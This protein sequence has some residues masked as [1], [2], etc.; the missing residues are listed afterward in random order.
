MIFYLAK[1]G[2]DD[3]QGEANNDIIIGGAGH[4]KLDGGTGADVLID[5]DG[6]DLVMGG[7]GN[8]VLIGSHSALG[9]S[10]PGTDEGDAL[11]G[12]TVVAG[13]ELF[14]F[15]VVMVIDSSRSMGAVA[16]DLVANVN[17]NAILSTHNEFQIRGLPAGT[18][19]ES[20]GGFQ[21]IVGGPGFYS[22]SMTKAQLDNLVIQL[23]GAE[24]AGGATPADFSLDVRGR[25]T[26][27]DPFQE[28][29]GFSTAFG[30]SAA[31]VSVRNA[32]ESLNQNFIDNGFDATTQVRV[33][34]FNNAA[35]VEV[36]GV[37]TDF[38]PSDPNLQTVIEGITPL[39]E[40]DFDVGI[41]EA[42]NHL[43]TVSGT[44]IIYF[45]SDGNDFNGFSP[46]PG[47]TTA[48]SNGGIDVYAY[49]VSI[50][51]ANTNVDLANLQTVA[52]LGE[53][54]ASSTPTIINPTTASDLVDDPT[55]SI[56]EVQQNGSDTIIAGDE[57]D[58][59]FG[60]SLL[61]DF[62]QIS[63]NS[64]IPVA[65]L[66]ADFNADPVTFIK[67]HIVNSTFDTALSGLGEQD[68]I[69]A[70]DG[71]DFVFGQGGHDEIIGGA[72]ND[73]LIGGHGDDIIDAGNQ[74]DGESDLIL[75]LHALDGNDVIQGFDND[76]AV[77]DV[78]SLDAIFD[79]LGTASGA[80][81]VAD[82]ILTQVASDVVVTI[83]GVPDFSLRFENSSVNNVAGFSVG[84]G[85]GDDIFVG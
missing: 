10:A 5:G 47:L 20:S 85:T 65:T 75:A 22:Q 51:A 79:A 63:I 60:D 4:D 14:T 62:S 30:E 24:F 52:D 19:L 53:F 36:F 27:L 33:V 78:V 46:A 55:D 34:S 76:G 35:S 28:F 48:I 38:N 18:L 41:Q 73:V 72:G 11:I 44:D 29:L 37:Q 3:L 74:N 42:V 8:D 50:D 57:N 1:P 82:T 7:T 6:R 9:S 83:N 58:V 26:A 17:G 64:A 12:D 15:N 61:V 68:F 84:N 81:R 13:E 39:G 59:I 16:S 40:A 66:M 80:A 69:D 45:F 71:D 32:V 56:L 23:P 77:H 43:T 49:G 70:G 67:S 31:I 54:S 2:D 25:S 21:E